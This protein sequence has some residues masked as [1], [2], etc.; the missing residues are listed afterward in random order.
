MPNVVLTLCWTQLPILIFD[1][2]EMLISD[3]I[4]FPT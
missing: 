1:D 3:A 4:E 2:R